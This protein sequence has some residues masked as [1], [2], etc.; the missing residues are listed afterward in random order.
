M[1]RIAVYGAFGCTVCTQP[2]TERSAVH[3]VGVSQLEC[4]P[5]VAAGEHGLRGALLG[6]AVGLVLEERAQVAQARPPELLAEDAVQQEVG[7]RVDDGHGLGEGAEAFAGQRAVAQLHR[8]VLLQLHDDQ[9]HC[10]E[11]LA[12]AEDGGEREDHDGELGLALHLDA[13]ALV[14]RHVAAPADE[15]GDDHGVEDADDEER[16]NEVEDGVE[17]DQVVE[18][19]EGAVGELRLAHDQLRSGH[20]RLRV[21]LQKGRNY[22]QRVGSKQ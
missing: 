6:H 8:V 12:Q 3:G 18:V 10:S 19:V 17:V 14:A 5:P 1:K 22:D 15:A 21:R 20:V 9:L 2:F 11:D 4:L 7:G 16:E 13:A